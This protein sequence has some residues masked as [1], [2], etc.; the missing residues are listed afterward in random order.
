MKEAVL[1]QLLQAAVDTD[2][3]HVVGVDPKLANCIEIGEFHAIDPLHRQHAATGGLMKDCRYGN[4]GIVAVELCELFCVGRLIEVVHLLEHP[5]AQFI[6]QGHQITA[7]Q[8]DV[9]VQPGG[10]IANDVKVQG[11]LF[12]QAWTLNFDRNLLAIGQRASMH[13]PE[14][15]CGDGFSIELFVD[16]INRST[17]VLL[18]AG[19]GQVTVEPR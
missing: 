2:I 5:T 11:D 17:E 18:D 8:A 14:G 9:A 15:G 10:D 1:Q 12:T 7:D 4:A 13:L 3:D 6:D 16:L 19:H